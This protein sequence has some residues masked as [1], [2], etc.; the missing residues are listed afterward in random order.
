MDAWKGG[1]SLIGCTLFPTFT[2]AHV[3]TSTLYP[4]L[5]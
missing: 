2:P 4:N 3:H 1:P 5:V